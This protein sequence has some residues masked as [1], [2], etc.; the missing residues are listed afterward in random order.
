MR[1]KF[2][3]Y[4]VARYSDSKSYQDRRGK[5]QGSFGRDLK[6]LLRFSSEKGFRI[7]N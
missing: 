1:A 6:S 2:Y 4:K 5:V 3:F 7:P